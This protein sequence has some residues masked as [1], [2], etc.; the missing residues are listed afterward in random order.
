MATGD[1]AQ[2]TVRKGGDRL[3]YGSQQGPVVDGIGV[4]YTV[5]QSSVPFGANTSTLDHLRMTERM[6]ERR[7]GGVAAI[8]RVAN[9]S[10]P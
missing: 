3:S 2:A 4:C 7:L 9:G 6:K 8:N 1:G 10:P 5:R